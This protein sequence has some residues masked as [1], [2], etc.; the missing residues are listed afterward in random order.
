MKL[1]ESKNRRMAQCLFDLMV[2]NPTADLTDHISKT[3]H[4]F[5]FFDGFILNIQNN[6]IK[7]KW[8]I[9]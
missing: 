4:K 9:S 3:D 6:F 2:A 7:K 1:I 5:I 8:L